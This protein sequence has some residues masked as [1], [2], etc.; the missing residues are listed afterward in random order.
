MNDEIDEIEGLLPW[1]AAG[2]LSDKERAAVEA[3][4]D[5]R[6]ELR[7]SL[8]TIE[9]DRGETI[10]LNEAAGAPSPDAWSRVLQG[11]EAAP[12]K[13]R[14]SARLTAWL[15]FGAEARTPRLVALGVAAALVVALQSATI[16]A[17]LRS[18]G[19]KPSYGTVTA[20]PQ[21]ARGA[22]VLVA[23]AP[24]VKL[25]EITSFLRAQRAMIVAGPKAGDLY[26]LRIGDKAL[27]KPDMDALVKALSASP[28]VKM[29]LPGTVQTGGGE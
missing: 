9:E 16:V 25:A 14:L 13:P 23:F 6:P 18:G 8:A 7:A 24:D 4:L 21:A 26:E 29:A 11:V 28:L 3:A 22:D 12:R 27:S 19:P 17:L 20:L 10:A 2:A 5:A 1:Y 15:G